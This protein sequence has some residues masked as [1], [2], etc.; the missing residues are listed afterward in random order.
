MEFLTRFDIVVLEPG[1]PRGVWHTYDDREG[2]TDE[3]F[4]R[5]QKLHAAFPDAVILEV[6]R[7]HYEY[8][9]DWFD[10]WYE[11]YYE[12][13]HTLSAGQVIELIRRVRRREERERR[14]AARA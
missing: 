6:G 3:L 7:V 9:D 10:W 8:A 13:Q 5:W 11:E 12:H 14:A 4:E 2:N 1:G